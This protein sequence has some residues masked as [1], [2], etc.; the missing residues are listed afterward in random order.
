MR[1]AVLTFF[2]LINNKNGLNTYLLGHTFIEYS[3]S[4][5]KMLMLTQILS[6]CLLLLPI[7]FL[8][9]SF[10]SL[11]YGLSFVV[12]NMEQYKNDVHI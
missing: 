8:L 7:L 12:D 4:L 6:Q 10:S 2:K 1:E 3:Y 9:F 5:S 11:L